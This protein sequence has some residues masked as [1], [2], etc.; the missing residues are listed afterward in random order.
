V[1]PQFSGTVP[2][3][4]RSR[5]QLHGEKF[6]MST[7]L[8]RETASLR[9]GAALNALLER[10]GI[11]RTPGA[12]NAM[13]GLLA[14]EAGFDCLYLSGA[15]LTASMGLPDLGVLTMEELC[16]TTR[17]IHRVT[18]L[19]IIV[20]GDT[21][22]GEALNVMRLVRELEDAGAAAVQ[23]EDQ[24]LPKKCGHLND[25]RLASAED[26]TAKVAAAAS[27]RTDLR[28]IARTDAA[29]ESFDEAVRRAKMFVEAG[30]DIIFPEALGSRE[31]FKAFADAMPGVPL[32]ANMTEFGRTPY[33]TGAEFE[34]MGYRIVIW[35]VSSLRV[36]NRAMKQLFAQ[37]KEEDGTEGVLDRM[38][39][40]AELY[41]TIGLNDYEALDKNIALSI[42]PETPE[43]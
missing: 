34:A 33:M 21:G 38:Q 32:L 25:K 3:A 37:M 15:A 14:K 43:G 28:I 18:G 6:K 42:A 9:P 11:I 41:E 10:P 13:A 23:I 30:A 8:N 12:H 1:P 40:R 20:D 7:W 31:M 19:P 39:T 29:A 26:M 24:I 22:Y 17:Q 5:L 27:A 4:Q 16:T 35:P 36:A 2:A